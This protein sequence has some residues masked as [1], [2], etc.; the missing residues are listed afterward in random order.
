M[1]S[2]PKLYVPVPAPQRAVLG[3]AVSLQL[4]AVTNTGFQ[5]YKATGL[6]HGLTINANTGRIS[7]KPTVTAGTFKSK[8]T[9]S[10]YAKSVTVGITWFVSSPTGAI[11][12]FD[13]K[14][15]DSAGGKSSNG[16]RIDIWSCTGKA[17]QRLTFAA[18]RELQLL[19]KCVTGGANAF[20]EP[21]KDT[22]N[23]A[24]TRQVNGEYVLAASGRCLTDPGSSTANG[25][26]LTL[27]ACKNTANQHWSLP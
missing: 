4:T 19:G 10:D 16:T 2:N 20:L 26:K 8:V 17:P 7:G 23:Q 3:K 9:I 12:G 11:R 1:T 15:V 14:C 6:P 13:A 21:C 24:W 18:N 27:A 25:T 5:K 22:S